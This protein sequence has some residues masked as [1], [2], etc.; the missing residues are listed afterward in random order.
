MNKESFS[1]TSSPL[2]TDKQQLDP[3]VTKLDLYED[4]EDEHEVSIPEIRTSALSPSNTCNVSSAS[5]SST[6]T[7]PT[8]REVHVMSASTPHFTPLRDMPGIPFVPS[9]ARDAGSPFPNINLIRDLS[10]PESSFR[11]ESNYSDESVDVHS[12][13]N[14][15]LNSTSERKSLI[16]F[17]E[18][19]E[20]LKNLSNGCEQI[21]EKISVLHLCDSIG[22]SICASD[23]GNDN[24]VVSDQL[25]CSSTGHSADV[26]DN[27]CQSLSAA[28]ETSSDKTHDKGETTPTK[29]YYIPQCQPLNRSSSSTELSPEHESRPNDIKEWMSPLPKFSI[30]KSMMS[31]VL[32]NDSNSY[33][34]YSSEYS[35][36]GNSD[37]EASSTEEQENGT[38]PVKMRPGDRVV[39]KDIS[40][41]SH[42]A[43]SYEYDNSIYDFA[44]GSFIGECK[45]RDGSGLGQFYE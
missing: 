6:D 25:N 9:Y 20:A 27:L 8:A 26:S 21:A 2:T 11:N 38:S 33:E 3:V 12:S 28:A 44:E 30:D 42:K 5:I 39:H 29:K 24:S 45:H 19:E 41:D 36:S 7:I 10:C 31:D 18:K 37:S 4:S 15:S 1:K 43:S 34:M 13:E 17:E 22:D 40:S 23:D 14:N 35:E 16:S 32:P